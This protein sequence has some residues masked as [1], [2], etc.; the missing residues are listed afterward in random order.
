[1]PVF[2]GDPIIWETGSRTELL[3]GDVRG[4]SITDTGVL[5]LSPQFSQMF[6]TEQPY[7]WSSAADATGNIYLGTGHDGK[8]YKVGPDGK[9][10]LLYDAAELDV[11]A[12][13]VGRDG[14]VYAGTSPDGKVYRITADGKA[15]IY[16]D[17][18]DKYIWSLAFLPDGQIAVGTDIGSLFGR[19]GGV[20]VPDVLT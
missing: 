19:S 3:R 17:P 5:L 4:V 2:G 20:A 15:D 12:L 8:V 10:A 1:M 18:P 7:V 6:N 9:G 16:F 13:A 11:T 14:A